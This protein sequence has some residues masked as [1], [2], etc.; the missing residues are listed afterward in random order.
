MLL[1]TAIGLRATTP[2][3]LGLSAA[4]NTMLNT[5]AL[6]GGVEQSPLTDPTVVSIMAALLFAVWLLS[7]AAFFLLA[8]RDYWHTFFTT[9]TAAQYT[10]R[11]RW[12]SQAGVEERAMLLVSVH[13]SLLRLVAADAAEWLEDNWD[14][15]TREDTPADWLTDEWKRAL[16]DSVISQKTLQALGGKTRRRTTLAMRLRLGSGLLVHVPVEGAS[17]AAPP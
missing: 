5:S 17:G 4:L 14:T 6:G 2:A 8:N 16:P 13:P 11:V 9:E 7:L 15:W 12:D 3:E 10:K 1:A